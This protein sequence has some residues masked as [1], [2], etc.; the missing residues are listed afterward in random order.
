MDCAAKITRDIIVNSLII[1]R[2]EA[3][4]S[5]KKRILGDN[6]LL[7]QILSLGVL[8][9]KTLVTGNK[10]ILAGNGGSF[11]DA[12]HICAEFVSKLNYDRPALASITLG[13][14]GSNMSAIGNDYGFDQVFSRELQAVGSKGDLFIAISTSGNSANII[15]AVREAK[16]A[17]ITVVGLTGKSGGLLADECECI[18]V[19]DAQTMHIQESH[20]L[21]GH[22][23]CEIAQSNQ[24]LDI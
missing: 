21:I 3:S 14:N 24:G 23:I 6:S 1:N 12:Q 9:Q 13:V 17:R 22:I 16:S 7:S 20:I 8:A 19:P 15:N 18:K 10:I 11:A 4:I 2:I 5:V